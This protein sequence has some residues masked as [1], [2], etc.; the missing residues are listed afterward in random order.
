M[1]RALRPSATVLYVALCENA[2]R[3][4]SNTF[5]ASDK[6]LASET[7]L[8]T[9]T[10]RDARIRVIE[11]GLI[12]VERGTGQSYTYTLSVPSLEWVPLAERPRGKLK[13]RGHRGH[14]NTI[15]DKDGP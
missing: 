14:P 15:S 8:S 13:P 4:G 1:A 6:A 7:T 11:K 10:I 5:K 2:N 9:R 3:K 12:T